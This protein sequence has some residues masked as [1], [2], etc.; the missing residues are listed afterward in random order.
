M[1]KIEWLLPIKLISEA[2]NT[3]HWTKKRTRNK[4]IEKIIWW[5]WNDSQQDIQLP[6]QIIL[7]RIAPRELDYDN[8]IHAFKHIRDSIANIIHPNL[9][10][11]QA[12]SKKDISWD[13]KQEKGKPKEYAVMIE[14]ISI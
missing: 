9:A 5:K 12:D 11:G 1:N 4:H 14:I 7:T 6:C 10:P 13:Y 2:N 8:L 3:D